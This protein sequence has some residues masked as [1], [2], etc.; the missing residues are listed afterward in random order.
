[1]ATSAS[2]LL[3]RTFDGAGYPDFT[4]TW[5]G[6]TFPAMGTVN[7][8]FSHPVVDG[9]GHGIASRGANYVLWR[10]VAATA[11]GASSLRANLK[12]KWKNAGFSAEVCLG[13]LFRLKDVQNTMALRVCSM[14]TA[15]PELRLV[16]IVGGVESVLKVWTGAGLSATTM[17]AQLEWGVRVQDL[18][19]ESNHSKV[20]AYLGPASD[21]DKGTEVFTWTGNLGPLRGVL[22]V[23]VELSGYVGNDDV[24]VDDLRVWDLRDEWAAGGGAGGVASDPGTGWKV[25]LGDVLYSLED[26]A[27]LD[28]PVHLV[29]C[30]QGYG[31]KQTHAKL[32][33]EGTYRM[34]GVVFP[35][36]RIVVVHDGDVRMRGRIASADIKASVAEGQVW[37]A[38]DGWHEASHVRLLEDNCTPLHHFNVRDKQ[39]DEWNPDRENTSGGALIT[40]LLDRYEDRLRH[41]G[42]VPAD[43]AGYA[44][45]EFDQLTSVIPDIA[46]GHTVPAAIDTVLRYAAH[47]FQTLWDPIDQVLHLKD[48]T[49]L[50]EETLEVQAEWVKFKVKPD[51]DKANTYIE[52]MGAKPEPDDEVKLLASKGEVLPA[53]TTEQMGKYGPEKRSRSMV[54][55]SIHIAGEDVAPDG[56]L[57]PYFDIAAGLLDTDDARGWLASVS[58]DA[59]PRLVVSNTSTRVWLSPPLWAGD[60]WNGAAA[61]PPPGSTYALSAVGE[62]AMAELSAQGVGRGWYAPK[63]AQICGVGVPG[64]NLSKMGQQLKHSGFCGKATVFTR[65]SDNQ[66][67]YSEEFMYQVRIPNERQRAAGFC[68]VTV[69]LSEKPK[70]SIGLINR[71][72]PK[73]G[74]PPQGLCKPGPDQTLMGQGMD[75]E[76]SISM[77]KAKAPYFRY[78]EQGYH[79]PAYSDDP[80]NW[81]GG[82]SAR[83]TDWDVQHPYILAVSD[84]VSVEDQKPG[85]LDACRDILAVKSTKPILLDVEIF[86]PWSN[87]PPEYGPEPARTTRFAGLG[88]ALTLV[89]NGVPVLGA[90]VGP[91]VLYSVT[92]MIE[93]NKTVLRVGTPAGWI[94]DK[95]I[96]VAKAF[97]E[98]AMQRRMMAK[99]HEVAGYMQASLNKAVDRIAGQTKGPTPACDVE[100]INHQTRRVVDIQKDDEDKVRNITHNAATADLMYQLT[101]GPLG[102]D[103]PGTPVDQPGRDGPAAQ[104]AID[105]PVLRPVTDPRVPFPGPPPNHPNATRGRYGGVIVT[106]R[107]EEG[108]PPRTLLRS[109]GLLD[110]RKAADADGNWDGSPWREFAEIDAKGQPTGAYSRMR[111]TLDLP[112]QRVPLKLLGHNSTGH[113]LLQM[114]QTLAGQLAVVQDQVT[115]MML[116]PGD[117]TTLEGG[118]PDGAPASL[119]SVLRANVPAD[120]HLVEESW[121]DPGGMVWRG[122]M[123]ADGLVDSGAMWRILPEGNVLIQVDHVGP[124]AGSNGGAYAPTD[125]GG[126][127]RFLS[128]AKIERAHKQGDHLYDLSAN[129]G[130]PGVATQPA[131][132][133]HNA[134]NFGGGRW[135]FDPAQPSAIGTLLSLPPGVMGTGRISV[136]LMEDPANALGGAFVGAPPAWVGNELGVQVDAMLQASPWTPP[137]T[138]GASTKALTGDQTGDAAVVFIAPAGSVDQGQR[139]PHGVRM[140]VGVSTTGA[141]AG[142]GFAGMVA[143][144]DVEVAVIEGGFLVRMGETVQ[145]VDVIDRNDVGLLETVTATEEWAREMEKTLADAVKASDTWTREINPPHEIYETVH[146]AD[147][148]SASIKDLDDAV[149]AVDNWGYELNPQGA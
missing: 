78:P 24:R 109:R 63:I 73:G 58:M 18:A 104:Q 93:A 147:V 126:A 139:T 129:M 132:D 64:T 33:V 142:G 121:N 51:R 118:Y 28:P 143:A 29:E 89:E 14:G 81:D 9:H 32:R 119:A 123:T 12:G 46:V 34:G 11:V 91:Q 88:K 50:P 99:V 54:V 5:P 69:T 101:V 62:D 110:F 112:N 21:T 127:Y 47:R 20:T 125:T 120:L 55:G 79:G 131:G 103:L 140:A 137:V 128:S 130:L 100:T 107:D 86:S 49:R 39:A 90:E 23:G 52:C 67:S 61:P 15:N 57:R 66:R 102:L 117:T 16:K 8:A 141:G 135:A 38:Y 148:W 84:F 95:G 68:D 30:K 85:L 60:W 31:N 56:I 98:A 138:V 37:T 76:L 53:W 75:L 40:W 10:G 122:P 25:Q 72:P 35:G 149:H 83:G 77:T 44:A 96:D 146:A 144:I 4:T 41:F 48:T 114:A 17:N 2:L 43:S 80:A 3:S 22:G 42:A 7:P 26:L 65:G 59:F 19:D 94:Q 116:Q 71:F 82:G 113:Q 92:W 74:S 108:K 36:Q 87:P 70:P 45:G 115:Q 111:T 106:D 136:H 133:A 105:G 134:W 97:S 6:F 27:E 145:A 13:L 1:M 124:G